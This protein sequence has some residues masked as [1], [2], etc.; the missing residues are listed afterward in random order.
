[1]KGASPSARRAGFPLRSNKEQG[2]AKS[3]YLPY[4]GSIAR[5]R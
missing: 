4:D 2:I 1:M 5:L 3:F